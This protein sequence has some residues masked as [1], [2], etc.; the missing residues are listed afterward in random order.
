MLE[1]DPESEEVV[2]GHMALSEN[3]LALAR[4]A[5]YCPEFVERLLRA[6]RAG[7][8]I[9]VFGSRHYEIVRPGATY[10]PWRSDTAFMRTF[11]AIQGYTLVDLYRCWN[12][13]HLVGQAARR[14]EANDHF[15]EI[16]VWR[17]GTGMLMAQRMAMSGLDQPIYLCDTFSGVVKAGADDPHYSGGEHADTSPP[18]VQALAS[19]LSLTN[20]RIC[21]GT[22][23]DH[24]P[25]ELR[26]G[27]VTFCHIDVDTYASARDCVADVWPRMATGG[28]IVF[29]DYGASTTSGVAK[30]VD[31]LSS[32][33]EGLWQY[34]L[35]GHAVATKLGD[36]RPESENEAQHR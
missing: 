35:N 25:T 17:G 4:A 11:R 34:N 15:I 32:Q 6:D 19:R 9:G 1:R 28:M 5:A 16:G 30:L 33:L 20:Y 14:C 36:H 3:V 12:L 18:V 23:P 21:I 7:H 26:T 27:R 24:V 10:A 8:P 22:F 13:W 31:E 2:K 29:D